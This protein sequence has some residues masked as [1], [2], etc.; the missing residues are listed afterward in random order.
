MTGKPFDMEWKVAED[1]ARAKPA[2]L[3]MRTSF[4]AELPNLTW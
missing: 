1:T 4:I 3:H 2:I